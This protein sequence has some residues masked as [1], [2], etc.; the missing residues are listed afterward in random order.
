M[1]LQPEPIFF[2]SLKRGT[3]SKRKLIT[4]TNTDPDACAS[5]ITD[6]DKPEWIE[7]EGIHKGGNI[8]LGA[9]KKQAIV[10]NVNTDHRFFPKN[11]LLGEPIKVELEGRDALTLTISIQEI[12]EGMEDFRGVLA[13]DFGTTNSCYASKPRYDERVDTEA[14]FKPADPSDEVPSAIFFTDVSTHTNPGYVVGTEA[15]RRIHDNAGQ[16]YSYHQSIKRM[17]GRGEKYLVLDELSGSLPDHR[18]MW[19]AEEIASFVVRDIL[20]R[21]EDQ[22]GQRITK[23]VATY[24]TLFSKQDRDSVEKIF[25]RALQGLGRQVG[26]DSVQL[27]L[28]E[29]SAAA[30]SYVY[31]VLLSEFRQFS[32]P[33]KVI[34]LL[35]FDFGGGTIDVCL[36]RCTLKR[37]DAVR[38]SIHTDV[39][40]VT[41]ELHYGGD[42]VTLEVFRVLKNRLAMLA[43]EAK[44]GSSIVVEESAEEADPFASDDPFAA[45]APAAAADDDPFAAPMAAA[46]VTEEDLSAVEQEEDP[47]LAVIVPCDPEDVIEQAAREINDHKDAI[48]ESTVT[49]TPIADI[50]L[51]QDEAKGLPPA[52]D[53][54]KRRANDIERAIERI[55][56]TK[57]GVYED[58]DPIRADLA[59][60]LFHELWSE[61]DTLKV[62]VSRSPDGASQIESDLKRIGKYAG[63][64]TEQ[65]S[66]VGL[67]RDELEGLISEAVGRAVTRA[68]GL[69][70]E[71]STTSV[72][73][74]VIGGNQDT[75]PLKVL[76]AGNSSNLAIVQRLIAETFEIPV[77]EIVRNPGG[78]KASVA[79]GAA[80]E[81]ALLRDFGTSGL[82]SYKATG[83]TDRIPWALGL[84]HPVLEG[85]GFR[86][87]FCPVFE[88]GTP[89]NT[90]TA[91]MEG[92]NPLVHE[93][94]SD[95]GVYA[96]YRDGSAPQ[97]L[98]FIDLNTP[99]N[100]HQENVPPVKPEGEEAAEQTFGLK[101]TLLPDRTIEAVDMKTGRKYPFQSAREHWKPEVNPFS[102]VH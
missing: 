27:G 99:A 84:Y 51:R 44:G 98:G 26:P 85:V 41:G 96:N 56:P 92:S 42:N 52:P 87:G 100:L 53:D 63:I 36:L 89:H 74:L 50:L 37:E 83:L 47:E 58:E 20:R 14:P 93:G 49:G 94:M 97:Y 86:D 18:Q 66:Q 46:E 79:Q 60:R 69:W 75:T 19:A 101:L 28:D 22:L 39:R 40:G 17:L 57:F 34:D 68:H 88:R 1:P 78:L 35:A 4:L 71:A 54:A 62:R 67:T 5:A 72:G 11:E 3:G 43:A 102:G 31:N 95:L 6:V 23:V 2:R 45:A 25:Q 70:Q 33:Q 61:A 65:F 8:D 73:G 15:L 21:A 16:S 48:A 32:E 12:Q 91:I 76:I 64:E 77:S 9:G 38:I 55:L 80:E 24:P 7:L 90:E 10:V 30:F 59:R 82:I 81:H 13:V 29:A